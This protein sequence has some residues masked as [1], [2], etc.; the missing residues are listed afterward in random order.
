MRS[1]KPPDDPTVV[2]EPFFR[3]AK[4]NIYIPL[5]IATIPAC[6]YV[7][8]GLI[9]DWLLNKPMEQGDAWVHDII[10]LLQ[11][12][13]MFAMAYVILMR[14]EIGFKELF[15]RTDGRPAVWRKAFLLCSIACILL[16]DILTNLAA[17]FPDAGLI[18]VPAPF[19]FIGYLLCV[20]IAFSEL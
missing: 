3:S 7:S 4:W 14:Y 8:A 6:F 11:L 9:L 5:T 1:M 19:A 15:E 18:L 2:S 20:R 13:G 12:A 10:V 16:F 17:A